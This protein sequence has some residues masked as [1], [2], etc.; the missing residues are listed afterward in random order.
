M[1]AAYAAVQIASASQYTDLGAM[2]ILLEY[3]TQDVAKP[4]GLRSEMAEGR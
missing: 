1:S 3:H 4:L 2:I